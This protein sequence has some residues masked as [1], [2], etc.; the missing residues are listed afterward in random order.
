MP[1]AELVDRLASMENLAG[2]PRAELEWLAAHGTLRKYA[3]G[4]VIAPLNQRIETLWIILSGRIVVRVD[5]GVGPRRVIEWHAGEVSGMLP[6]S[7]MKGPPGDNFAEVP[8]ELL[9]IREEHFPELIRECP[10]FTGFTVHMML[11]RARSFNTSDLQDEK[12]VSL[13]KLAAGLAHELN[14]PASAT[15]RGAKMLLDGL[16]ETEGASRALG[17]AGLTE[18]L[19][20]TIEAMRSEWLAQPASV[21]QFD[22]EETIA[23]W[24]ARHDLD[25]AHAGSLADTAVTIEGLDALAQVTSGDTLDAALRWIVAGCA[26]R[27][28]AQDI[29]EAATRI[30]ELVAAVKSFTHMDSLAGP[31]LVDVEAGLRDTIRVVA[32][33]AEAKGATITLDAEPD[34]PRVQ[35][36]G[37]DL[38]QVWMNLIDNALDAIADSGRVEVT[39]RREVDRVVVRVIDNGPGIPADIVSQVFDPFFTTKPPGKGTGLGLEIA[40][41]LVRRYRGNISVTSVPGRAEFRVSLPIEPD[42]RGS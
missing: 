9:M 37:S 28:L 3:P 8:T 26:T 32:S 17:A 23:D 19:M 38:N 5:R 41:Q 31:M 12:M 27:M 39:A 6:F 2:I 16:V 18:S 34:L 20:E 13:G 25:P 24:L 36:A 11:D 29:H 22:R 30:Y 7:R 21:S 33:K 1:M 14:N 35:A 10:A 4:D 42:A 15:M 40:R